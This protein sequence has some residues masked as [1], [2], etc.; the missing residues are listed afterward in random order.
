M[1]VNAATPQDTFDHMLGS[2]AF[3]CGW[4]W[5][6]SVNITGIKPN[7]YDA[8]DGWTAQ[9]TADDGIGGQAAKTI[10]HAAVMKAARAVLVTPPRFASTLLTREC[11]HLLF[12][13]DETD[14][15]APLADEL[16]QFMVL[17]GPSFTVF[18]NAAFSS[19]SLG[20]ILRRSTK[21]SGFCI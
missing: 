18:G 11:S 5:W 17:G 7:G 10:D 13:N 8:E 14:F 4:D 19:P 3:S 21:P 6:L 12:D 15:D 2:G 9:I 1:A 20:S 16:L